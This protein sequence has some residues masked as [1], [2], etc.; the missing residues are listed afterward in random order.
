MLQTK[1]GDN[2][3]QQLRQKRKN[4]GG[5]KADINASLFKLNKKKGCSGECE[6]KLNGLRLPPKLIYSGKI[7]YL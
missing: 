3:D 1:G 7:D 5:H 4:Y 2:P 6:G